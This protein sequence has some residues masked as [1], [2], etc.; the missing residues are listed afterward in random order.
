MQIVA[1]RTVVLLGPP[2]ASDLDIKIPTRSSLGGASDQSRHV[3]ASG[4]AMG[5]ELVPKVAG[6][7]AVRKPQR[8]GIRPMSIFL[9]YG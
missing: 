4:G 8:L 3:V 6:S 5:R 1:Q 2:P 9:I 7:L